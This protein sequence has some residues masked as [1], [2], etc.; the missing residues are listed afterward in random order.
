MTD[1]P[2]TREPGVLLY[3]YVHGIDDALA[4]ITE[5]GGSIVRK[6]YLPD[7]NPPAST[8][9]KVDALFRPELM[10]EIAVDAILPS[11]D[12]HRP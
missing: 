10:L 7:E 1:R 12:R 6:P 3:I 11:A 8:L 2:L 9:L 5:N 4:R